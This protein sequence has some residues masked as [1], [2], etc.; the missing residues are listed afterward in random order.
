MSIKNVLGKVTGVGLKVIGVLVNIVFSNTGAGQDTVKLPKLGKQ[1]VRHDPRTFEIVKYLGTSIPTPPKCENWMAKI[2]SWPMM[3]NDTVGDCTCAAA[4]HDEQL[5]TTY[6]QV[7]PFIPTTAQ[8][9][10]MYTGVTGY[11]P[12]DPSTDNGAVLL[13]VLNYWRNTGLAGHKIQAYAKLQLKNQKQ[14]Q[15]SIYLFGTA[16]IG[17]L[18]PIAV[19]EASSWELPKGQKLTGNWEPGS[20]GGHCVPI[21]EYDATG[22]TVITWGAPL[23][24]SYDF[25]N[26]Y[27]DEAYAVL[28]P[29][30]IGKTGLNPDNF[31]LAALQND[32]KAL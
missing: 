12:A 15:D 19:Q 1:P 26:A 29:D 18:L 27:C 16:Y 4:G 22:V 3:G 11:N 20:W 23:K 21:V 24:M 31:N 13:D 2:S 5:W 7:A 32:L 10:A 6:T 25:Y 14:L 9:L 8:V 17:L 28:S 30:W